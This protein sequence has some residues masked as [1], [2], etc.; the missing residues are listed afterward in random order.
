MSLRAPFPISLDF[1]MITLNTRPQPTAAKRSLIDISYLNRGVL[2]SQF[3]RVY[4]SLHGQSSSHRDRQTDHIRLRIE[5]S[6]AGSSLLLSE[7]ETTGAVAC[8]RINV[9]QSMTV[10]VERPGIKTLSEREDALPFLQLNVQSHQAVLRTKRLVP[11]L[12]PFLEQSQPRVFDAAMLWDELASAKHKKPAKSR[13]K[14]L[15]MDHDS[16]QSPGKARQPSTDRPRSDASLIS[17]PE[18]HMAVGC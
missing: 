3:I 6:F 7:S 2:Y 10:S 14:R 18:L 8:G 5:I 9:I 13:K 15:P 12:V 1:V 4:H 11:A 16:I 17:L